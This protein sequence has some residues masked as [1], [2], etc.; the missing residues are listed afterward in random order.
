MKPVLKEGAQ[1][2]PVDLS[3][4]GRTAEGEA[5]SLDRRLFMQFLAFGG[6]TD[7]PALIAALDDAGFGG[8]LYEDVSDAR[9]VGL[10]TF[11]EEPAFF[12]DTLRP[13]LLSAPFVD[14]D[15]KPEFTMTGRTYSIG[16]EPNLED[17]LLKRLGVAESRAQAEGA[18]LG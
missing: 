14:L 17:V 15:A 1:P 8:V 13:F 10:V 5:M 6:V 18:R 4:K 2:P 12:V 9:G 7:A 16:Y 11:S 3:E